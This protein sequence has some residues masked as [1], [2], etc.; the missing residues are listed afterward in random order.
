MEML[1]LF[2]WPNHLYFLFHIGDICKNRRVAM[3]KNSQWRITKIIKKA[4]VLAIIVCWSRA[5]VATV[6]R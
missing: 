4:R 5:A 3:I 1:A 2:P 6:V